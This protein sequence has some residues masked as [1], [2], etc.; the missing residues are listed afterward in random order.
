M[1]GRPYVHEQRNCSDP[2]SVNRWGWHPTSVN[3]TG[4]KRLGF[5]LVEVKSA[6]R[7]RIME[8]NTRGITYGEDNYRSRRGSA[9]L[10]ES[11]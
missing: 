1:S 8:L 5:L 2:T 4:R 3:N 6:G 10:P 9:R 11:D 7:N